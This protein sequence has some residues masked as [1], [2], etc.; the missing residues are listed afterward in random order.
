MLKR[1]AVAAAVLV[2]AF[3]PAGAAQDDP[4]AVTLSFKV[5]TFKARQTQLVLSGTAALP[6]GTILKIN[7]ARMTEQALRTELQPMPVGAGSGTATVNG[8]KFV[9]TTAIPSP[10]KYSVR[11]GLLDD[12]QDRSIAVEL[13]KKGPAKRQWDFEY[14]VWGDE[15]V[16]QVASKLPDLI[17]LVGDCRELVAKF[18]KAAATK[19]QWEAEMKPLVAEGNKL[20]QKVDYHELKA[21]YPASVNNLSY[22]IRNVVGNAPY[23]TYGADGKFSGAKD[24]HADN[25]QVKTF[26]GESFDWANLKRY[27]EQ[28]PAMGG[29]E[30]CLWVIK[31]LRRTGGQMRPEIQE[32]IKTHKAAPGV[33][34]FQERLSKATITDL[35]PLEVQIR[36]AKP[37]TPASDPAPQKQ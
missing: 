2:A 3:A 33:D 20:Q 36:G 15:L 22:T 25:N 7:M 28:T 37:S 23:Y 21:F 18:E 31:D 5:P 29:R 24:Y 12:L 32:A 8:K 9:Y 35:D 13:K 27:V 6:D 11:I 19:G 30:F 26:Q 34:M 16:S 1:I 14:L 17:A 10:S 4:F